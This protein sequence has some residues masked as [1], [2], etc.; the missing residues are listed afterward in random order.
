MAPT[1]APAPAPAS[2]GRLIGHTRAALLAALTDPA[3]TSGL[4]DRCHVPLSTA[5]DH[6]AALR[7]ARLITTHRAGHALQ[8]QRTDLGDA[9][10]YAAANT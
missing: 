2:L 1:P 5:S 6:L 4:A 3:T 8:H 9:L 10:L 7:A